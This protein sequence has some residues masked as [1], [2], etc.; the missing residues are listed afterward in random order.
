MLSVRGLGKTFGRGDSAVRAIDGVSF[1]VAEGQLLALV[2]PSGCGKSTTLRC[3]A[4]LERADAGEIAI[5]GQT[6]DDAARRSFRPPYDRA[7]GMVFQSYAI[8][9]HLDVFENVAY[10]LRV[11]R[12]R[13]SAGDVRDRVMGTLAL[14]GLDGLARRDATTLSGGQQ[15]R[16]ALARALVRQPRLLL[17]DEPLSNLD[18]RLREQMQHELVDLVRRVGVTTVHVTHDQVEALAMA[19]RVAVM[20]GGRLAQLDSPAALYA[21][22]C[23]APVATFVGSGSVLA[24]EI[25]ETRADQTAIVVLAGGAGRI[26]VELP[27]GA[28]TGERV[29]IATRAEHLTLLAEDPLRDC[30]VLRGRIVRL[31]FRGAARDCH[32]DVAGSIVRAAIDHAMAVQ[33]GDTV[34]LAVHPRSVILFRSA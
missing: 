2:G 21:R 15:Q 22:P 11:A 27:P 29:E 4:G 3:I 34:W 16:V 1:E 33:P 30:N 14:V 31:S 6:V 20:I 19:D 23:S 5:G 26:D 28:R 25:A 12:A 32:V 18:A 17:L 24:G 7:I 13:P 10:P 9:P 8:W